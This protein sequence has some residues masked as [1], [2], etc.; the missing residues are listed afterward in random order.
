LALMSRRDRAR[1][2]GR[3]ARALRASPPRAHA[4]PLDELSAREVL[5]LLDEEVERLPECYRLPVL[6]CCL[7]GKTQEE[8]ARQLGW[9]PG[10]VKG[11]LERGRARLHARLAKRGLTLSAALGAVTV[12]Q[13]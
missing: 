5:T 12:S 10:S 8:A 13:G 1:R 9:T 4:D 11:R 6:L 3:Q 7:E 2:L